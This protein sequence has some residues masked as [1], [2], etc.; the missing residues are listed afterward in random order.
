M[1]TVL[2]PVCLIVL[3]LG[4]S[5]FPVNAQAPQAAPPTLPGA[6]PI[7]CEIRALAVVLHNKTLPS[8]QSCL[9][10]TQATAL[11][12]LLPDKGV[13]GVTAA[14]SPAVAVKV[15]LGL[16]TKLKGDPLEHPRRRS[17]YEYIQAHPGANF[18]E[19]ARGVGS[20]TGTTRHHLTVLKRNGAV[21]ERAHGAT[22]RFFENHGK[23]EATWPS[24]VLLRE[25]PLRQLHDWLA[26]H[27]GAA[28]KEVLEAMAQAG[29]SRSTTQH[30]LQRL[31]AGGAVELRPQG[32]LKMY[33]TSAPSPLEP[34]AQ[35]ARTP[36]APGSGAL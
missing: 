23:F 16:F 33:R 5:V 20:A 15:L 25:E 14:A 11:N 19:I 13:L 9:K 32:R 29:W 10:E 35:P 8:R 27:P 18:R 26:M 6:S 22:T 7:V 3:L 30:R 34:V 24:V 12:P 21:M 4:A 36:E 31:V 17:I 28:Q 1:K 2:A